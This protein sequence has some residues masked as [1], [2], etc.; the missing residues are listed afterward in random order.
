MSKKT[1]VLMLAM[2]MAFVAACKSEIDNKPAATVTEPAAVEQQEEAPAEV[3]QALKEVPFQKE[4]SAI[5]WVGA[6]VTGDH[7]G[8]FNEWTGTASVDEKGTLSGV[9][10]EVDTTSVYS[11][12]DDLT[13]HLMSGD[14]FDVEKFPKASFVS[15]EITENAADGATHTVKGNMDLR[16]VTKEIQ[17]PATITSA[18]GKLTA[19]SEFTLKRTD[20]GINYTGMADD[21]IKEDV[22]MKLTFVADLSA[23][24][25]VAAE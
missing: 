23:D 17:F 7:K 9:K 6:K 2:A 16:G 19:K 10:F 21:L 5:E 3:A 24:G 13:K 14:F 22:L 1:L 25:T 8:G 12:A 11:D 20:F 18:D 15:T 4:G